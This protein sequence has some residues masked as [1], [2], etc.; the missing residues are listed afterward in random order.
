MAFRDLREFVRRLEKEGELKRV[1]AEVD[2]VLEITGEV[3]VLIRPASDVR[4]ADVF[5]LIAGLPPGSRLKADI[6]RQIREERNSWG[7]R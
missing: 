5:E 2:P 6:D 4:G 7:D 3:E 1:R